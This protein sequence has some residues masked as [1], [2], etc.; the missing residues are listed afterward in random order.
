[1]NLFNGGEDF[2]LWFL[3]KAFELKWNGIYFKTI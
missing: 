2:L 3:I 1:M